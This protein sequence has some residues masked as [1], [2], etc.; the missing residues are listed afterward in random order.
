MPTLSIQPTRTPTII[1]GIRIRFPHFLLPSA[2]GGDAALAA[3]SP[4]EESTSWIHRSRAVANFQPKADIQATDVY[5]QQYGPSA[6]QADDSDPGYTTLVFPSIKPLRRP[7]PDRR[8]SWTESQ[9]P[10]WNLSPV[11]QRCPGINGPRHVTSY[12]W[13]YR[14]HPWRSRAFGDR[15]PLDKDM[16]S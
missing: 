3:D 15:A 1:R 16:L 8:L 13:G 12:L 10:N 2:C 5:S 14:H 9:L 4:T 11:Q 6:S 7:D